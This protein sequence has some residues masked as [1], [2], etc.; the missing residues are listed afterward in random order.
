MCLRASST[1]T[2]TCSPR[3]FRCSSPVGDNYCRSRLPGVVSHNVSAGQTMI[4][5]SLR[6]VRLL[7]AVPRRHDLQAGSWWRP[8]EYAFQKHSHVTCLTSAEEPWLQSRIVSLTGTGSGRDSTALRP[9]PTV[10]F[11]S[12]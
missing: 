1:K 11:F 4:L 9:T 7:V 3:S 5:V 10:V 8:H 6:A 12:A 2:H